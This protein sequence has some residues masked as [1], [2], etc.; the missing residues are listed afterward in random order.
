M[1][2]VTCPTC[3]GEPAEPRHRVEGGSLSCRFC[4]QTLTFNFMRDGTDRRCSCREA[5]EAACPTCLGRGV[6]VVPDPFLV[7]LDAAELRHAVGDH[8]RS[9]GRIWPVGSP[10]Y[11]RC[12]ELGDLLD[13]RVTIADVLAGTPTR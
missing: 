12:H 13:P 6:V 10:T 11:A 5:Q 7:E 4:N 3:N 9:I 2:P 1:N 8:M